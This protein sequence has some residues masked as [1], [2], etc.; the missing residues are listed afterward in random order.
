MKRMRRLVLLTLVCAMLTSMCI[1]C[2]Q[3]PS[4]SEETTDQTET[5]EATQTSSKTASIALSENVLTLD[6]HQ[7]N[8]M[9]SY[10]VR[11]MVFDTLIE[12]DHLGNYTPCLATDWS[13]SEDGLTISL[14][15]REGVKFHNG[16]D[17]NSADVVCTFQRLIDDP[18]LVV[19]STYWPLL[20]KVTAIDDYHVELTLSEPWAG[21]PIS[22]INTFILPDEAFTELGDKL[23]T[24]QLLYGTGPWKFD[25][26][27]DGQHFH[28]V[29]NVDYWNKENFDSYY[30]DVYVRIVLEPSTAVA[31]H[32]A[33]DIQAYIASGGIST[34][35]LPLYEGS[36]DRIDLVDIMTGGT[37]YI[38]FQC[39][40][41]SVFHDINVRKA[42]AY[43][44]DRQS[45]VDYILGAGAVPR[46][47]MVEDRLGASDAIEEF[48]YNPELAKEYLAK[49]DYNGEEI[50]FSSNTGTL[51]SQEI[52]VAVA[53]MLNQVGFNC[54]SEVV[55][56]ATLL[57]MRTTGNYDFFMVS[58]MQE[59]NDPI[60]Y[61]NVY[62]KNDIHSHNYVDDELWAK[63]DESNKT[64]D[65]E[66]RK[67]LLEE[68]VADWSK[69]VVHFPIAQLES[70]YAVDKDVDGIKLFDDGFFDFKYVTKK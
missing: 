26:W 58:T 9:S 28:V 36:E 21:V 62:V 37:H 14:T 63:I 12:T 54:K 15:L 11:Q 70:V 17:F 56:S 68:I 53:E 31:G 39:G 55:E 7:A 48:P 23:F 1:G 64:L 69:T 41:G 29:K 10:Q 19:A 18:T 8:N 2:G 49:S 27:V 57:E 24:D 34:D 65:P 22:L 30:D 44:I 52:V 25:E 51:K 45:I 20:T 3:T 6:P 33:G 46:S 47:F 5:T 40:E 60:K 16:E 61:I 43:A 35:V 59:C 50:T 66:K 32:V 67:A 4:S 13:V 42:V 38:G